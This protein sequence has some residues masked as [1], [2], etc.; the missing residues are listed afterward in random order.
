MSEEKLLAT[1]LFEDDT[2]LRKADWKL[3][4]EL[5]EAMKSLKINSV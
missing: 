4:I 2:L 3:N 1:A 5:N